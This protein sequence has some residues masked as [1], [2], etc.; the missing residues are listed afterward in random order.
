LHAIDAMTFDHGETE[1][2][3]SDGKKEKS[4]QGSNPLSENLRTRR[5]QHR[6]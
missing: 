2:L 6:L 4:D 1:I 5:V 3:I